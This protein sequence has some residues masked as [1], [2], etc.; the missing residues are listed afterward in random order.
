MSVRRGI[1]E[2]LSLVAAIV[3]LYFILWFLVKVAPHAF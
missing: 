2:A 3:G 1:L